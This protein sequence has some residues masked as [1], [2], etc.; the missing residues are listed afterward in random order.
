MKKVHKA[1]NQKGSKYYGLLSKREL[2]QVKLLKLLSEYL[3]IKKIANLTNKSIRQV[4]KSFS[5]YRKNNWINKDRSLTKQGFEKVQLAY[6]CIEKG[7]I[8]PNTIRL[9]DLRFKVKVIN[10]KYKD[11]RKKIL[12]LRNIKSKT[13]NMGFWKSEQIVIDNYTIQLNPNYVMFIMG[14]YYGETPF[15]AFSKSLEDLKELCKNLQRKLKSRLFNTK[16][17][18]FE[19]SR[20]HYALVKNE[21]AT[22][23]NKEHKKLL[24]YD[25]LGILRLLIDNSLNLNELEAVSNKKAMGDIEITQRAL[26]EVIEDNIS[27]RAM[28]KNISYTKKKLFEVSENQANMSVVLEQMNNNMIKIVKKLGEK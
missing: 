25:D 11:N 10:K 8:K 6:R 23:Y 13:I 5:T 9:H 21:I 19:V 20:N 17:L 12:K 4:Y 18:D 14:D 15:E 7:T 1:T 26:K 3:P 16:Y 2:N 24:V 28:N 27:F 22:Q